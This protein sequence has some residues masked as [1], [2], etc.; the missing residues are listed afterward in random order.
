LRRQYWRA[1]LPPPQGGFFI[2]SRVM[3][4]LCAN[5]PLVVGS[6][7]HDISSTRWRIRTSCGELIQQSQSPA[8]YDSHPSKRQSP[9]TGEKNHHRADCRWVTQEKG[10]KHRLIGERW[11]GPMTKQWIR[12][13]GLTDEEVN[14]APLVLHPLPLRNDYFAWVG[15]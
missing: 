4:Q 1:Q 15:A 5:S 13:D 7:W 12:G 10:A 9:A 6:F 11:Q 3:C 2:A 14:K 8:A